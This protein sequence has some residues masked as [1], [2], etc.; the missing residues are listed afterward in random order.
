M[1]DTNML[2]SQTRVKTQENARKSKKNPKREPNARKCFYISLCVE[3]KRKSVAFISCFLTGTPLS[4]RDKL[5]RVQLI[6]ATRGRAS[7]P[8]VLAMTAECSA[9]CQQG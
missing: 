3:K 9:T 2:V 7:Q 4:S 5:Y 6:S 8:K 1:Y